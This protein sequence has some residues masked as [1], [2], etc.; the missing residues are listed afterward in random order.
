MGTQVQAR[1]TSSSP[2]PAR[3]LRAARQRKREPP[4][5]NTSVNHASSLDP[6]VYVGFRK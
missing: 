4:W 3:L 6:S 2:P 5:H 1:L